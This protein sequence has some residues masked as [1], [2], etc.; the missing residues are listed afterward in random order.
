MKKNVFLIIF[1]LLAIIISGSILFK[2]FKNQSI[3]A[4]AKIGMPAP[5]FELKDING[6]SWILDKLK[7]KIVIL[8]F[9]ASWCNECK[10]EKKSIQSYINK[11]GASDD[12][13]FLTIIYKDNPE[14][15]SDIVKKNGYTFPVLLDNG[16][17]SVIYGIKGVPETFLIDKRGIL[18][19]KI[20]GPV[21]WDNPHII[22]HL[23]K[24]LS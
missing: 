5:N 4:K 3:S 15:V 14:V 17:I 22:P 12:L 10:L 11:N 24:V 13:V 7:G 1:I 18:R 16:E 6:N 23:K 20:I 19:H 2:K 21:D 9:W 8:N